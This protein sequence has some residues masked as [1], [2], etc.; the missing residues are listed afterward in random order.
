MSKTD[1]SLKKTTIK[2]GEYTDSMVLFFY[3]V[4]P[5]AVLQYS[6]HRGNY[7]IRVG[8]RMSTIDFTKI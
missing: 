6:K 4:T 2:G 7:R 1:L 8:M 5:P 3:D